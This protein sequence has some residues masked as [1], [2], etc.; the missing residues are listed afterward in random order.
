MVTEQGSQTAKRAAALRAVES[1]R[2][3]GERILY[4]PYAAA[5]AGPEEVEQARR[6]AQE[7]PGTRLL[8][9]LRTR[10]IDEHVRKC[11]R[12]GAQQDVIFGAGYDSTAF[13]LEELSAEKVRVFEV[14]HPATSVHKRARVQELLGRLPGHVTYIAVDFVTE[15]LE[16][17]RRKLLEGGFDRSHKTVFVLGGVVP[18]LTEEALDQLLRFI[19]SCSGPGSSVI[20]TYHDL[21]NC[22]EEFRRIALELA[23]Q[24]EPF[25]FGRDPA[26]ME[27]FLGERGFGRITNVS[28]EQARERYAPGEKAPLEPTYHI[29]TAVAP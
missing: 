18:Y 3:P 9:A 10:C 8:H 26:G 11:V 25:L 28:I 16:D 17:L 1:E 12:E 22:G 19:A 23:G 20:L 5:F 15:T 27:R 2:P 7:G 21:E 13:R 24:G 6:R 14:D 29:A 4:D